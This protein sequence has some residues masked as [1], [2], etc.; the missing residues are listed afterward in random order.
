MSFPAWVLA[1]R[2]K[3]KLY[4][5]VISGQDANT[6][7]GAAPLAWSRIIGVAVLVA[8]VLLAIILAIVANA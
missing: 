6:I 1:Y 4:R 5:V 7:T 2:Y 3:Q 8:V